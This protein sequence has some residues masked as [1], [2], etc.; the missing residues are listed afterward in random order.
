MRYETHLVFGLLVGLISLSFIEVSNKFLYLLFVLLG[1]L[2]PDLDKR[3]S[4]MANKVKFSYLI[5]KILGH[6]RIFH[7]IF[8]IIV[9]YFLFVYYLRLKV[10][11]Y[12]IIIGYGSHLLIDSLNVKGVGFLN[13]V[14][15]K[16]V[17]WKIKTGGIF[18][19]FLFGVS[20]I[21]SVLIIG[22]WL[23]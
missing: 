2:L 23:I 15:D 8:P 17:R 11:G 22:K 19:Y 16:R 21:L 14:F 18:E 12:G 9:L 5:E 1:S 20:L 6:R 10:M 3:K 4:F 7:S 13:P